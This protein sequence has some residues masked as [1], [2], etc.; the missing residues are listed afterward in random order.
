M[1][2]VRSSWQPLIGKIDGLSEISIPINR[3]IFRAS[4]E[5]ENDRLRRE[6]PAGL[7]TDV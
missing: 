5:G 2:A 3:S 7:R 4:V 1:A 6:I